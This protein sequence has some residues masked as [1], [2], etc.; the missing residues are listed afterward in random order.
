LDKGWYGQGV[1]FTSSA[2]Y[3]IP[4]FATKANPVIIVAYVIPGNIFPIVEHPQWQGNRSRSSIPLRGNDHQWIS[5]RKTMNDE[6]V[7]AQE[8]QI[9]PAFITHVSRG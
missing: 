4:Y 9:V 1:Y 5:N 8:N 2:R 3:A 6:L 7:V